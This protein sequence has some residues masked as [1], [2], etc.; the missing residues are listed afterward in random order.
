MKMRR[1]MKSVETRNGGFTLI[2]LLVVIAI[3][4]ILAAML[5]PALARAKAQAHRTQCVN[6]QK[7]IGLCF[8][9]YS[10]DHNG[11]YTL[12]FGWAAAGGQRGNYTGNPSA[13][14]SFGVNIPES[15]RPLNQYAR[16][17]Q[18]FRCPADKGDD[19]YNAK[20][21]FE[22]YG[23][24]YMVQF[25]EDSYR[26][27]RVA[28]DPRRPANTDAGRPMRASEIAES[29]A[30][31]IIQGDWHWHPNRDVVWHNVKG[32]RQHNILFG[33]GHVEYFRLPEETKHQPYS[34]PPDKN[35]LW[36]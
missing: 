2:E 16:N 14:E 13:I 36:W 26:V 35:W 19:M 32:K 15:A 6:N 20:S 21:C 27:K 18:L 31:K 25:R 24:S 7:Q 11:F 5:L 17:V 30:N 4:A 22:G 23:N 12:Q 29:P 9:M 8:Q 33:D 1:F 34:P 3:I 10:E 28:A